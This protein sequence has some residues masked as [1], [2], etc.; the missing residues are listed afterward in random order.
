MLDVIYFEFLV[1]NVENIKH[2]F[3][4]Q[5]HFFIKN[6]TKVKSA[7]YFVQVI[8]LDSGFFDDYDA[9]FIVKRNG[10]LYTTQRFSFTDIESNC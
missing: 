9:W 1:S 8:C 2:L 5:I 4:F 7:R 6:L 3:C 10:D